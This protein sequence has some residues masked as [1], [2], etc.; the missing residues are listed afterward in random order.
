MQNNHR[1]FAALCFT[2]SLA[3]TLAAQNIT[4]TVNARIIGPNGN[5][6]ERG[7]IVVRD[8]KIAV[9]GAGCSVDAERRGDRRRGHDGNAWFY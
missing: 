4:I 6:I 3:A 1:T 8:G 7:S 9:G 2:F 5:V